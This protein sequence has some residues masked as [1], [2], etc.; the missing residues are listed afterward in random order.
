M[1]L[2]FKKS[3]LS[4][5]PYS[6]GI[7]EELASSLKVCIIASLIFYVLK[8]F[9]LHQAANWLFIE[10]GLIVFLSAGFNIGMSHLFLHRNIQEEKW[11]VWKEI[12]KSLLFLLVN[13]LTLIGFAYYRLAIDW[14]SEVVFKFISIT[15]LL[16]IA[17][18]SVRVI[19]LNNWLLK[20]QLLEAQQLTDVITPIAPNSLHS[21][22]VLK[23]NIVKEEYR[24]DT[25]QLQFIEAEKNYIT[26]TDIQDQKIKTH[27]LRLSLIKAIPQIK[28]ENIVRCHR[29]FVVNLN[30]VTKVT[31]NSQGLKLLFHD[32]LPA[33]PVSRTYSKQIKAK[34]TSLS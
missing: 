18:I 25:A 7:V 5:F 21:E 9:G 26:I 33:I 23:S 14:D 17:P 32:E 15:M 6:R 13:S 27:L 34:L 22:I 29:S 24:T 3:L 20:K 16:A 2:S 28:N 8:P 4:P 11:T 12:I 30:A 1:V 10:M 19:S 31:G